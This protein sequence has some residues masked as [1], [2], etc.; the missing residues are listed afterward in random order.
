MSIDVFKVK[1]SEDDTQIIEGP[2]SWY[3][4][5]IWKKFGIIWKHGLWLYQKY[6][7]LHHQCERHLRQW[8]FLSPVQASYQFIAYCF[9]TVYDLNWSK[10]CATCF[11]NTNKYLKPDGPWVNFNV[12]SLAVALKLFKA[13]QLY[14]LSL[15]VKLY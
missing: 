1:T 15:T 7:F 3:S 10:Y 12:R 13:P 14:L 5:F 4:N 6:W 9:I 2:P 8:I 11:R